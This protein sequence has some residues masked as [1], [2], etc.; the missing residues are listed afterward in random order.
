MLGLRLR[1]QISVFLFLLFTMVVSAMVYFNLTIL[2]DQLNIFAHYQAQNEARQINNYLQETAATDSSVND[3]ME[4]KASFNGFFKFSTSFEGLRNVDLYKPDGE[5]VF[6]RKFREDVHIDNEKYVGRVIE[7]KKTESVTWAVDRVTG[8][9]KA[10]QKYGILEAREL[11]QDFYFPIKNRQGNLIGVLHLS[12]F[13]ERA[14][15]LMRFFLLGN[16]SLALIFL[17]TAFVMIY[18]W[19]ENAINKPIRNL[20]KAQE[21]LSRGDFDVQVD[22][23]VPSTNELYVIAN[24]FNDMA[25]E[26]KQY[27]NKLKKQAHEMEKVNQQYKELN[28]TLEQEVEK[29]TLEL[30]E[31]FSLI[32]HDLKIP[33]AAVKGYANL[34]KKPKTGELNPKQ[35]KFINSIEL[36]TGQL[37]NMV[38]NLLDSVRY[39]DGRVEYYKENFD[40]ENLVGEVQAH[41]HP[42]IEE[43]NINAYIS[44][45]PCCKWVYGD[46]GKINQVFL[47]IVS[48]AINYTPSGGDIYITAEENEEFVEVRIRDSGK[49][50]PPEQLST[51]FEKFQQVPNKET[52]STSLGLGLYI[53]KKI[54]EGHGTRVWVESTQGKG[55]SFYFTLPKG[56]PP[57]DLN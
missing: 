50:I 1:Y 28:E 31:F 9:G 40:L 5:L 42:I 23:K 12:M 14:T 45:S 17:L 32:T 3:I 44:I 49:G 6:T 35:E 15:R 19:S 20:I 41:I 2:N 51:I 16:A 18:V 4:D 36:A 10:I 52:P 26:I 11:L 25:R 38:K 22:L 27:Q 48:N 47:N 57:A 33:L 29:K 39:E 34:L 56:K 46:R 43:K 37:L 7:N 21:R 53:V 13:L 54:I 30:K 8:R 55:S 24:S